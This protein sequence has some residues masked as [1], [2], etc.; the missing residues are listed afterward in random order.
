MLCCCMIDFW[1]Q[2]AINAL[3]SFAVLVNFSVARLCL[4]VKLANNARLVVIQLM[5]KHKNHLLKVT[6]LLSVHIVSLL[7]VCCGSFFLL[8]IL[9]SR[10]FYFCWQREKEEKNRRIYLICHRLTSILFL[11]E[12]RKQSENWNGNYDPNGWYV[13]PCLLTDECCTTDIE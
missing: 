7:K 1:W 10:W 3:C 6:K 11:Y 9:F 2:T 4:S 13:K 12:W 5:A 8:L